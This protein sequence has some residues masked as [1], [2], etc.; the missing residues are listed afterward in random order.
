MLVFDETI[1]GYRYYYPL[2]QCGIN[3]SAEFT[4]MGKAIANGYSLAAV[5]ID[6]KIIDKI[7]LKEV[8]EFSTTHAGESVG[9]SA[10]ISTLQFYKSYSVVDNINQK[11]AFLK[12]KM[13]NIISDHGL[14]EH[15]SLA[16]MPT[17][18]RVC[19]SAS[20]LNEAFCKFLFEHS[21]LCRGIIS[22]CYSHSHDDLNHFADLFNLFCEELLMEI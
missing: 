21:V 13:N 3:C 22:V 15:I 18:F 11:G 19:F 20:H 17:Y 16:G 9:L 2:A 5:L 6:K 1:S 4:V 10:A 12:Q 7:N 14:Q 8:Y